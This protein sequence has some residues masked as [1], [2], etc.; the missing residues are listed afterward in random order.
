MSQQTLRIPI[1]SST[2]VT[3]QRKN[4]AK[5]SLCLI[6]NAEARIVNYGALSCYS[7]KTFFRRH[8]FLIKNIET[9][10][11]DGHCLITEET[12]KNCTPCRLMKCFAM[13]MSRDFIRKKYERM[14]YSSVNSIIKQKQISI[15][16][17]S[18]L[19]NDRSTLKPS[20]W[21]TLSNIIHAFDKFSIVSS[22]RHLIERVNHS[23]SE[24]KVDIIDTFN[25]FSAFY[26]CVESFLRATADFQV[27]TTNE[28][29]S[30]FQRNLHGLFNLCGTFMLRDAGMFDNTRNESI[31]VPLYGHDVVHQAREITNRLDFNSSI[32]KIIHIIF[33]FSTNCYTVTY[34]A[35]VKKDVF[36]HGTF[37]LLGSQ[38]VYIEIL[39]KY[40]LYR[41]GFEETVFRFTALVKQMLDLIVLSAGIYQKNAHHQILVDDLV[42]EAKTALALVKNNSIPLWGKI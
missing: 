28:Q 15:T 40:M 26:T 25:L 4:T 27:L 24:L 2:H 23:Q 21:A 12:R 14:K 29:Q 3:R 34:Q 32:V 36:L 1:Q 19:S 37:R 16:S 22:M 8:S 39:W 20:E 5:S 31:I 9:C 38:N 30:L 18:L 10:R 42:E 41:F 13:G 33:A 17:L 7:C 35:N 11:Y 6:C